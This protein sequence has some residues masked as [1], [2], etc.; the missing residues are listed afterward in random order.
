MFRAICGTGRILVTVASVL[1]LAAGAGQAQSKTTTQVKTFEII[2]VDGNVV[3]VKEA[4]GTREYT[5]PA[6]FRITV[7]EKQ[8]PL[9]EL[10]P[11]MKGKATITT[12]TTV[13]PVSVTEVKNGRVMKNLGAG[14][15]IVR[16]DDGIKMFSQGEIDK[17]GIRVYKDARPVQLA[18]LREG[19]TLTATFITEGPPQV[20]TE[21]QVEA[22]IAAAT[23][24]AAT[25][26]DSSGSGASTGSPT[27]A[28]AAGAP[29]TTPETQV[30]SARETAAATTPAASTETAGGGTSWLMWGGLIILVMIVAVFLFRRSGN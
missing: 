21:K 16:T 3:V 7:G 26:A 2:S 23:A 12:T 6:D 9:Q 5:L 30:A 17:R 18:D 15:V 22:T 10:K 20:L 24:T 8:L 27:G 4:D 13:K 29:A 1:A 25:A 11:G 19:D 14:S 28:P